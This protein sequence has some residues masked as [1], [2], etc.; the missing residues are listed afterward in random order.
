MLNNIPALQLRAFLILDV[1][2]RYS[3]PFVA[4]ERLRIF[5]YA[6]TMLYFNSIIFELSFKLARS[7][8]R[9]PAT[10]AYTKNVLLIVFA[11]IL[12]GCKCEFNYIKYEDAN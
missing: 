1:D 2:V 10:R 12:Y 7:G 11:F 8:Q 6:I 5:V 4:Q 3:A 9:S